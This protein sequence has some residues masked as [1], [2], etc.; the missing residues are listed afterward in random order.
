MLSFQNVQTHT[1]PLIPFLLSA[2]YPISLLPSWQ[3]FSRAFSTD[4]FC[5]L[6]S[7][8]YL[9][10]PVDSPTTLL[11]QLGSGSQ[12]HSIVKPSG[13]FSV[14]LTVLLGCWLCFC[15][16][17]DI[18]WSNFSPISLSFL[19]SYWSSL[20]YQ[21]SEFLKA[22][23]IYCLHTCFL[24]DLIQS[25]DSVYQS[26]I[27][28]LIPSDLISPELYI[29][30]FSC[31]LAQQHKISGSR[32][33]EGIF[34]SLYHPFC[35]LYIQEY[36]SISC[37]FS[38]I[39]LSSHPPTQTIISSLNCY[40]KCLTSLLAFTLLTSFLLPIAAEWPYKVLNQGTP[41]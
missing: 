5:F 1:P 3:S 7:H 23:L 10:T 6:S 34:D 16:L 18:I 12:T 32:I 11:Y 27:S 24:D 33:S 15:R 22:L 14:F 20:T 38:I 13:D 40:K 21:I 31:L 8:S 28:E 17:Y 36:M 35:I 30:I 9:N 2:A 19:I 25:W 39:F 41:P 37:Q 29:P 4:Y 26:N